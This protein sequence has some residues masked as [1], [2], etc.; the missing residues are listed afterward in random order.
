MESNAY[1][2]VKKSQRE[3]ETAKDKNRETNRLNDILGWGRV[4]YLYVLILL[5]SNLHPYQ[6]QT[7]A[8]SI[9]QLATYCTI[10]LQAHTHFIFRIFR[11]NVPNARP[12]KTASAG[13]V[14]WCARERNIGY[15]QFFSNYFSFI[16]IKA[17]ELN[18]NVNK[19]PNDDVLWIFLFFSEKIL[20]FN[21]WVL[22]ITLNVGKN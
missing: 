20:C 18:L 4:Q 1:H 13:N 3:R 22:W 5:Q 21:F 14:T 17:I 19:H 9:H 16:L 6:R 11:C 2:E 10:W 7:I 15:K 12:I 8:I